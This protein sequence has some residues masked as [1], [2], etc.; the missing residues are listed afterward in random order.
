MKRPESPHPGVPPALAALVES[1]YDPILKALT[2][3][4]TDRE[5]AKDLAQQTIVQLCTH[6]RRVERH[7]DPTAWMFKVA[8]N[9][10]RSAARRKSVADRVTA[11][12][13]SVTPPATLPEDTTVLGIY[14]DEA[15]IKLSSELQDVVILR[16]Y[17]G[18]TERQVA[19]ALGM[20]IGTVK[21]RNRR[22]L[23]QL[24]HLLEPTRNLDG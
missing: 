5:L 9:L 12:Q 20:P 19:T 22:A 21:T 16:Y 3:H 14:L 23:A 2:F 17:A 4:L 1:T 11:A 6:W 24:A 18:L 10:G 15:L 7:P 13:K 8:F